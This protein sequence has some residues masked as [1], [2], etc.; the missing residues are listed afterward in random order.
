MSNWAKHVVLT[1]EQGVLQQVKRDGEQRK[2]DSK[3][4]DM[5]MHRLAD[6]LTC[7][8][9]GGRGSPDQPCGDEPGLL[10]R[11]LLA[12]DA[13]YHELGSGTHGR[14]GSIGDGQRMYA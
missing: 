14:S 9:R 4:P 12:F 13:V 6:R 2:S 5:T 7:S 10:A 8:G 11:T 1:H 3:W